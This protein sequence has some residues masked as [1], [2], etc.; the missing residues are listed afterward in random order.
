MANRTPPYFAPAKSRSHPKILTLA[1]Q[2]TAL[3]KLRSSHTWIVVVFEPGSESVSWNEHT[4]M[5]PICPQMGGNYVIGRSR[6]KEAQGKSLI[7]LH[8]IERRPCHSPARPPA[9]VPAP[10]GVDRPETRALAHRAAVE[11]LVLLRNEGGLLPLPATPPQPR[12]L[13]LPCG[14]PLLERSQTPLR[15]TGF[16]PVSG[17]LAGAT[18]LNMDEY[19]DEMVNSSP[20]AK[21][22]CYSWRRAPW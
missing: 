15:C 3:Q 8:P 20:F 14:L 17:C 9:A 1:Y 10:Q 13:P 19:M 4:A 22:N 16:P 7:F 21:K 18:S 6:G 2:P 12:R 5:R 11:A